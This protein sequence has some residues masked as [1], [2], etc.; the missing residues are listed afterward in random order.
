MQPCQGPWP[1]VRQRSCRST[2]AAAAAGPAARALAQHGESG[3]PG[4]SNVLF[5][6]A[7]L[8]SVGGT[9]C[10]AGGTSSEIQ[11]S[12]SQSTAGNGRALHGM[13][14]W[15]AA[16]HDLAR[17]AIFG[18]GLFVLLCSKPAPGSRC[19]IPSIAANHSACVFAVL[20]ERL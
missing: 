8:C 5:A 9:S 10:H 12:G 1:S 16:R 6:S 19:Q 7:V 18:Q 13:H 20:Q 3:A 15:T 11:T 2:A 14:M 17:K 4:I